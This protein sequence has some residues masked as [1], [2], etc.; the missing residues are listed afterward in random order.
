MDWTP[1]EL[2]EELSITDPAPPNCLQHGFAVHTKYELAPPYPSFSPKHSLAKD[3]VAVLNTGDSIIALAVSVGEEKSRCASLYSPFNSR[4][5]GSITQRFGDS[6]SQSTQNMSQEKNCNSILTRTCATQTD[7]ITTRENIQKSCDIKKAAP[8]S[9]SVSSSVQVSRQSHSSSSEDRPSTSGQ[10]LLSLCD[11][12]DFCSQGDSVGQ[13]EWPFSQDSQ[14][15]TLEETADVQRHEPATI[16]QLAMMGCGKSFTA[17]VPE[18]RFILDGGR[19]DN[20]TLSTSD[21]EESS[22]LEGPSV[23][24]TDAYD[25]VQSRSRRQRKCD[26][27]SFTHKRQMPCTHDETRQSRT[28]TVDSQTSTKSVGT[29]PMYG[30]NYKNFTTRDRVGA[31]LKS[32]EERK[33]HDWSRVEEHQRSWFA[34]HDDSLIGKC[35]ASGFLF[36]IVS[37]NSISYV[38]Y[39]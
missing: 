36:G 30:T 25:E 5:S 28:R 6:S 27:T 12:P 33:M 4:S 32:A 29:S 23:C 7:L 10:D 22:R 2:M 21:E 37:V 9:H 13:Q 18:I 14:E 31:P 19:D 3:G 15:E 35:K 34:D 39:F 1:P 26:G 17:S 24:I 11:S 8:I 20:R 16:D 38:E